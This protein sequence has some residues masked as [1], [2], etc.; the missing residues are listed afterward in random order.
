ME[1][2]HTSS[3]V[4]NYPFIRSFGP[5]G[6]AIESTLADTYLEMDLFFNRRKKNKNLENFNSSFV[7]PGTFL[8]S[9]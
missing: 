9:G 8:L 3:T 1:A 6:I 2:F 5:F 7:E 4:L